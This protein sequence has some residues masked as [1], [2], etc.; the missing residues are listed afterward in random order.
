MSTPTRIPGL[1]D[2]VVVAA[3]AV[4][5]YALDKS[6]NLF[7]WGLIPTG[8]N[9][10]APQPYFGE[11]GTQPFPVKV[12]GLKQTIAI[13]VSL[14]MKITL[15]AD[16]TV[17]GFGP[18]VIGN[19]GDGTLTPH[20]DPTQV[21][22]LAG[23]VEIG[24]SGSSPFVALLQDGTIRYWGGCCL[25]SDSFLLRIPTAPVAGR[26]QIYS[27]RKG[28]FFGTL[29]SIRHLKGN[30][31]YVLLYGADG[32]LYQFPKSE[33]EQVFVEIDATAFGSAS[34]GGSTGPG[35]VSNFEGLWWN[36]PAGS[37]SGWGINFAHQGDIIFATWFT[38]D[39]TGKAWW[40]SM[41]A[42]KT[43]N[44][45]YA[46]TLYQTHGPA[47]NAMPF[48]PAALTPPGRDRAR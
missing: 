14:S 22:G 24:A 31:G 41:T 36:S 45:T 27:S 28:D 16:G 7:Q 20:P 9:F 46:G 34:P 43:A 29:P 47:F 19:F 48:S 6:G 32:S 2:I 42:S 18:N 4:T 3:D 38:Y 40:L 5:A 12:T 35:A 13:A 25:Q 8:Y 17:W 21:P 26:T 37:E 33:N 1:S 30:G 23:V 44:N 15:A 10:N 39:L 11:Y